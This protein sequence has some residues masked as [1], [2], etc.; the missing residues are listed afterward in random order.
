MKW[1]TASSSPVLFAN[2]KESLCGLV[3]TTQL[4][5]QQTLREKE[6]TFKRMNDHH[7]WRNSSSG[8]NTASGA[9]FSLTF[10]LESESC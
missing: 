6:E 4:I 2:K 1:K 5:L 3:S 8:S 10:S 9:S 7:D